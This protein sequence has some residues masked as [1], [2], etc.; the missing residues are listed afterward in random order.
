MPR[1]VTRLRIALFSY[2]RLIHGGGF[3]EY[4]IALA[5]GMRQRGHA[6][7]IIT[8]NPREY[9]GLNIA[10]NIYYRNPL[11]HDNSRVT[12]AELRKRLDG[13]ELR[14]VSI[15]RMRRILRSFDVIY[16]KNEL[17]DLGVLQLLALGRQTPV[18]CGVHTP[19]WYPR[20]LSAQARL[21]NALYLGRLYRGLL[22]SVSAVHVSNEN[23]ERLFPDKLCWPAESLYRIPYPYSS[24]APTSVKSRPRDRLH[25]FFGGRLT[26]QKGID[27]LLRVL[28]L[29]A[30]APES[31]QYAFTVA[32]SGEPSAERQ[33][34]EI[35]TRHPSISVRGHVARDRMPELYS[36]ADVALV[37][38]NWETFPFACLEPQ[39]A[40]IPVVA[41]DIPGCRDIVVDG[42]TGFLVPP[43]KADAVWDALRSLR[44]WQ[45]N[46]P[47]T[48]AA[49]GD[50]AAARVRRE[51]APEVI[52]DRLEKM[53]VR[54]VERG[55]R[56]A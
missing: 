23:D 14:E 35:A 3:E 28:E 39:G 40:G 15:V 34:A 26:Q 25:V 21:H 6:V 11:L 19:M 7:T 5:H 27:V 32:G 12:D 18:I 13:V 43:G 36:A 51:F 50:S 52:M 49:M 56:H 8:A 45:C 20:A 29:A 33:L 16:S 22:K 46:E 24:D 53:L 41:S 17:L 2:P 44:R 37:P 54:V 10:L 31:D 48:L 30:D 47:A 4:L 55:K 9:R 38:S 42:Q 1:P